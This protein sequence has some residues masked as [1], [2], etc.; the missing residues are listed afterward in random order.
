MKDIVGPPHKGS[1]SNLMLTPRVHISCSHQVH[2]MSELL[3]KLRAHMYK[4]DKKVASGD[5]G[6]Q[7]WRQYGFGSAICR[8]QPH[9]DPLGCKI[10]SSHCMMSVERM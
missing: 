2:D 5:A 10:T 6:T 3:G 1:S 9:L 4:L 8:S 7:V